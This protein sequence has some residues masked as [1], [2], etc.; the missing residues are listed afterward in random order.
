[1]PRLDAA[2]RLERRGIVAWRVEG[3]LA[4]LTASQSR[5]GDLQQQISKAVV[6]SGAEAA[7]KIRKRVTERGDLALNLQASDFS[8]LESLRTRLQEAGLAVD[9]GSASRE[10]NGVSAR[11]VIGGNG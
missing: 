2:T 4:R 10:D 7:I 3:A 6:Q 8:A 1:M 11:L 9:M 5:A